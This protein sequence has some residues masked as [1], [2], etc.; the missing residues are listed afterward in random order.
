MISINL[1]GETIGDFALCEGRHDECPEE[2]IFPNTIS[3]MAFGKL[4][5]EAIQKL[6]PLHLTR[7]NIYTSGCQSGLVAVL[8]AAWQLRIR[9]VNVLHHDKIL[10]GWQ[11]QRVITLANLDFRQ[12]SEQFGKIENPIV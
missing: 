5:L 9:E 8:N 2:A 10:G 7:L 1:L 11:S 3:M 4:E 12:N 6:R